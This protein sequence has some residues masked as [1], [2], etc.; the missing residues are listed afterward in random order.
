MVEIKNNTDSIKGIEST[1]N[2][3]SDSMN[4]DGVAPDSNGESGM[5]DSMFGDV[6]TAIN[7]FKTDVDNAISE[8]NAKK[9][10]ISNGFNLTA[11]KSVVSNCP[12][13]SVFDL[14]N[15]S[16]TNITYD[17]CEALTP[18]YPT[19]YLISY[20]TILFS[21]IGFIYLIIVGL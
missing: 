12:T 4:V 10:L 15:G 20:V 17:Y 1:L 18:F 8:L 5:I 16:S 21:G 6:N 11:T 9:D 2:N 14:G 19:G 3:I 13:S 7:G